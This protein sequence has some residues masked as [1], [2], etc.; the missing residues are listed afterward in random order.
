MLSLDKAVKSISSCFESIK[1]TGKSI[2]KKRAHDDYSEMTTVNNSSDENNTVD[3]ETVLSE[4]KE[5]DMAVDY[6]LQAVVKIQNAGR[7]TIKP[8]I[9]DNI[10]NLEFLIQKIKKHDEAKTIGF[11]GA[12]KRGKSSL[13][14]LLLGADLM[15]VSAMPMSSV[16]IRVKHDRQHEKGMF[17]IEITKADGGFDG[18][19]RNLPLNEAQVL[20]KNYG[21]HK[22][23]LSNS[24]DTIEVT[25][26]F[27]NS[28][29]L[30]NGGVLIDTPGAE[31][32]F[33]KDS[34]KSDKDF[35]ADSERALKILDSTHIVVFVERA[36]YLQ[37]KNA[38]TLYNENLKHLR[39][40]NVLNFKDEYHATSKTDD[41][42][43]IEVNKQN[44]MKE[45]M[46]SAYGVNLDRTICVSSKEAS[47]SIKQGNEK[48]L[49]QSNLPRL[50]KN[51]L[52]E[53]QNLDP[54]IGLL[55]C[56]EE[57]KKILSKISDENRDN[58]LGIFKG[59]KL[60]LYVFIDKTKAALPM[61]SQIAQEIYNEYFY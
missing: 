46:L 61:V 22:G 38:I 36:D 25:S 52:K 16:V 3:S 15:P 5:L 54:R 32:V 51:I 1:E 4:E 7:Q 17:T 29:I 49:E 45:V 59:G 13:I 35:A 30:E 41:P 56:L 8:G 9:M 23:F 37:N 48:L 12:P 19:Y 20:L 58:A 26:N 33:E 27:E 28:K 31:V 39:P 50:E 34:P 55:T 42:I 24:V 57:L 53:L 47:N 10:A 21:S 40:L 43:M 60:A 44:E 18:P 2:F 11:F 6:L 14:N